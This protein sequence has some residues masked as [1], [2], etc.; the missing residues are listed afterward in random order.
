MSIFKTVVVVLRT[1]LLPRTF[2][3]AQNLA[4]ARVDDPAGLVLDLRVRHVTESVAWACSDSR[5]LLRL[6]SLDGRGTAAITYSIDSHLWAEAGLLAQPP[7]RMQQPLGWE[8]C[9]A[10]AQVHVHPRT[11]TCTMLPCAGSIGS[12]LTHATNRMV[13]RH[14]AWSRASAPVIRQAPDKSGHCPGTQ[15]SRESS[16]IHASLD[17]N[18]RLRTD[19]WENPD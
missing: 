18:G 15:A 3:M 16:W 11:E 6:G 4:L 10:V 13:S 7:E 17:W 1:V 12:C 14:A 5:L 9:P 8:Q 2:I 19:E